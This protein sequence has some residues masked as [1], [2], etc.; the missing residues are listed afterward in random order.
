MNCTP[1]AWIK[2]RRDHFLTINFNEPIWFN[3]WNVGCWCGKQV[4]NYFKC[5]CNGCKHKVQRYSLISS[6]FILW[7]PSICWGNKSFGFNFVMFAKFRKFCFCFLQHTKNNNNSVLIEQSICNW[8][9]SSTFC[10]CRCI[11]LQ[12]VMTFKWLFMSA[13]RT[14]FVALSLLNL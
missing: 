4:I 10:T 2:L 12:C 13:K 6:R 14:P 1:N 9:K 3:E 11:K 8:S 5:K 7:H